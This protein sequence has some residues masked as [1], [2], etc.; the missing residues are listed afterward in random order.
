[1][2]VTFKLTPLEFANSLPRRVCNLVEQ[3]W[4]HCILSE[5]EIRE[6][7]LAFV[8]PNFNAQ[9]IKDA[10]EEHKGKFFTKY[11][12]F[13]VLKGKINE[14]EKKSTS[15]WAAIYGKGV[16]S[17]T[18]IGRSSK[19]PMDTPPSTMKGKSVKVT[20]AE[21]KT[22]QQIKPTDV[23]TIEDASDEEEQV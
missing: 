19:I 16:P 10:I 6:T 21:A 11:R 15:I 18:K 17:T 1:M 8:A 23:V 12:A 13:K 4:Q 14:V 2:M 3:K 7:T 5:R 9:K 22:K 20:H